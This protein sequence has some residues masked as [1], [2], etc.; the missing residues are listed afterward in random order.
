MQSY[1]QFPS[2]ELMLQIS[3]FYVESTEDFLAIF[4]VEWEQFTNQK[5]Q[6]SNW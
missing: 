1:T 5:T 3:G 4:E 2:F 6:F